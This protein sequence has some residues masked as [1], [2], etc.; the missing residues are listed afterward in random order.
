MTR[1]LH[2]QRADGEESGAGEQQTFTQHVKE[3]AWTGE[4]F[5]ETDWTQLE[6][7]A[8]MDAATDIW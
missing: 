8:A 2:A 3:R 4:L 6:V 7:L 5:V 1:D